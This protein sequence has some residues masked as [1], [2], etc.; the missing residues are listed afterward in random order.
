MGQMGTLQYGYMAWCSITHR[1][2]WDQASEVVSISLQS[3][4][5]KKKSFERDIY[6]KTKPSRLIPD[7]FLQQSTLPD[8]VPTMFP[9]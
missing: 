7:I 4:T 8:T 1:C 9:Q 3:I 2:N 6:R 5:D